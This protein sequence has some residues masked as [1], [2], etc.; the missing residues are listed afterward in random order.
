MKMK[1]LVSIKQ[2]HMLRHAYGMES[3]SPGYRTHY[4]TE[5][6]DK[7]MKKLQDL[8]LFGKAQGIGQFG[9]GYAIFHLTDAGIAALKENRIYVMDDTNAAPLQPKGE[10]WREG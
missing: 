4:C 2:R 3:R 10:N 8:G 7:D 9:E 1:F 6:D 5:V